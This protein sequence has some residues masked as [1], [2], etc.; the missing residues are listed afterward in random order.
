[1]AFTDL[2]AFLPPAPEPGTRHAR[3]LYTLL[4]DIDRLDATRDDVLL[5]LHRQ[6]IGTGVHYRALH[7]HPDYRNTFGYRP[8]DFP[9]AEWISERTV[10]LPLSPGLTDED[11]EDGEDVIAAVCRTLHGLRSRAPASRQVTAGSRA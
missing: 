3:H 2:A 5:D 7:L 1:V 8:G 6:N 11:G 4:V 9:N 10:S